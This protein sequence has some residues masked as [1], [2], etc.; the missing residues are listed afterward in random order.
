MTGEVPPDEDV[1]EP[2]ED[3]PDQGEA[4]L[5]PEEPVGAETSS[6]PAEDSATEPDAEVDADAATEDD[7]P[8]APADDADEPDA[9]DE[10]DEDT[11]SASSPA[12]RGSWRK[13]GSD[14]GSPEP[15]SEFK[16]RAGAGEEECPISTIASPSLG[17]A[18]RRRL[19][20]HPVLRPAVRQGRHAQSAHARANRHAPADRDADR[21]PVA[22]T[23]GQPSTTPTLTLTPQSPASRPRVAQRA[24]NAS[25]HQSDHHSERQPDLE[26]IVRRWLNRGARRRPQPAHDWVTEQL[27]RRGIRDS[28]VLSAMR[29]VPRD[30]FVPRELVRKAYDDGALAIGHGQTIS[31]PYIVASMT[32]RAGPVRVVCGTLR[33]ATAR[34]RRR[35]RFGLSGGGARC[36]GCGGGLDRDRPRAR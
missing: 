1:R 13:R 11:P 22:G 14:G 26:P 36:A 28:A 35:H 19:R 2:V 6:P 33:C 18:D 24:D 8:G 25:D 15:E 31:Q 34:A 30:R 10:P 29:A 12:K 20:R 27:E 16:A 3:A 21:D 7:V 5:E 32:Q 9:S 4:G 17:T 23:V